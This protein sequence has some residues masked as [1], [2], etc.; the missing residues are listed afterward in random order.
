[1]QGAARRQYADLLADKVFDVDMN[2]EILKN[3][4]VV[5]S[6][7]FLG[8]AA[9]Y[10]ISLLMKDLSKSLP[11]ATLAAN[12]LGCLLIGCLW[13]LFSRGGNEGSSWLSF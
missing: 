4:L 9:R 2:S 10:V 11:W 5:G 12:L 8:G 13:G 7:S 1:M 6:G 3:I